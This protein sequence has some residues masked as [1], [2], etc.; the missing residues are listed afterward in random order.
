MKA[1]KHGPSHIGS[2]ESEL[3]SGDDPTSPWELSATD[4]RLAATDRRA[5]VENGVDISPDDFWTERHFFEYVRPADVWMTHANMSGSRGTFFAMPA[6]INTPTHATPQATQELE[7]GIPNTV[8][9]PWTADRAPCESTAPAVP[10]ESHPPHLITADETADAHGPS[11]TLG[12][13]S[14]R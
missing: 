3:A 7:Y 14:D 1:R 6:E 5:G 4:L 9:H 12:Q 2:P 10:S 13:P 11:A 8:G